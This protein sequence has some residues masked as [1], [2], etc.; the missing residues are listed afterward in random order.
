[1]RVYISGSSRELDHLETLA[2]ELAGHP[3]VTVADRWMR[4]VR[5]NMAAGRTDADLTD[6]E[7][8]EAAEADYRDIRRSQVFWLVVPST[9]S[10]GAW[11]ELGLVVTNGGKIVIAS[12]NTNATIFC[13]LAEVKRFATHAEAIAFII[14]RAEAVAL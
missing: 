14:A 13:H 2:A 10:K 5:A 6:D 3:G 8:H 12:G 1:M 7:R 4:D 9:P 11:V